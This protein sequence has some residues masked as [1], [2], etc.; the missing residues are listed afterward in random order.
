MLVRLRHDSINQKRNGKMNT[1][2]VVQKGFTLIEVMIVVAIIGLI[3]AIAIP[4][5]TDYVKQGKAAEATGNLADLRVKME[6]CFQ[7]NRDYTNAA[8]VALCA[9]TNGNK[10]FTYTCAVQT[11]T[12][13]T[14][15]AAGKSSEDMGGFNFTVDQANAKTST[16]DGATGGTCW[17]TNKNGSC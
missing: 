9:P 1:L 11:A 12:T 5:Y 4:S 6:Q 13:Y 3:A 10:Y 14:L 8:C 2:K 15:N 17:L 16:Y 7:D